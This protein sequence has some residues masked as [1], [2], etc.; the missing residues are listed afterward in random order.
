M[1]SAQHSESYSPSLEVSEGSRGQDAN[2][3]RRAYTCAIFLN[4]F[5]LFLV[6]P[7]IA[8]R[9]LPVFG[10][11]PVVWN[12]CLLFF[13][14]TLLL[15][16]LYAHGAARRLISRRQAL[17]HFCVL[18]AG[19]AALPIRMPGWLV[20]TYR[21]A[22]ATNPSSFAAQ[23]TP[24]VLAIL[25][26]SVGLPFFALSAGAPFIQRWFGDS[27]HPDAKNPYF[28]YSAS[29][30]GSLLALLAYPILFEPALTAKQ[31]SLIWSGVY[32]SL[33][34]L[35]VWVSRSI[36]NRPTLTVDK[37]AT[38]EPATI[39]AA[40]S[41]RL[42]WAA[43][44]AGPSAALMGVTSYLSTNV[45][46]MP[47][48]WVAPLGLYLV[49]FILAFSDR[50]TLPDKLFRFLVPPALLLSVGWFA[51]GTFTPI[52][53]VVPLHL[54]SFFVIALAAHAR[55]SSL[56]PH[57]N[58]LTEFYLWISIGGAVGGFFAA[59]VAPLIFRDQFELPF[60][61]GFSALAL[62]W[63][64]EKLDRRSIAMSLA[65]AI[66]AV[67]AV[68]AIRLN[69]HGDASLVKYYWLATAAGLLVLTLRRPAVHGYLSMAF[70]LAVIG[71]QYAGYRQPMHLTRSFFGVHRVQ[72]MGLDGYVHRLVHGNTVHGAQDSRQPRLAL[73]YF[74]PI[75]GAGRVLGI[76]GAERRMDHVAVVGL[77]VG[78]LAAYG[79]PGQTM[80]LYEL[81]PDV[82]GIASDPTLFTYLK[83]CRASKRVLVGD[84]RLRLAEAKDHDYG[85]LV[86]DAF[87]SDAIPVHLL[88]HEAFAL[89]CSKL[90][91]DGILAFHVSN[92]FVNLE[93]V[94]GALARGAGLQGWTVDTT[95]LMAHREH[96]EVL[97]SRWIL[98]ARDRA[99]LGALA[100]DP[101]LVP[102]RSTNGK[103]WT[104]DY[105]DVLSAMRF[106]AVSAQ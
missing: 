47:L 50:F 9:I 75:S 11:S 60:A 49:T 81:D 64:R 37:P 1:G 105:S 31:T 17:L 29:N 67:V 2:G 48:L 14:T 96:R 8:K 53:R 43:L 73:T 35:L 99:S 103:E 36:W 4:A 100:N 61:L 45:A 34:L 89:Y 70:V 91:P 104:D 26:A 3:A 79:R 106:D 72:A 101:M 28:L 98:L 10:G 55:V 69:W 52:L 77:G 56:K 102:L 39:H 68:G 82:V 74:S 40:W 33:A 32:A 92:K 87:S 6:Q 7:L 90:R 86:L 85:C 76:L 18:A 15:G 54:I 80:D 65:L 41:T 66:L 57:A 97:A 59:I 84:A 19:A 21:H 24:M 46:P 27:G 88:T 22:L 94:M 62:S 83:G 12:A 38:Q 51:L 42:I 23:P 44:A 20:E 63:G 58:G 71:T 30:A 78:T 5:L 13:Q 95:S 93:P 25:F 16:Y